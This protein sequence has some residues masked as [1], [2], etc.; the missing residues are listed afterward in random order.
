MKRLLLFVFGLII[1]A[2]PAYAQSTAALIEQALAAA[3]PR[4][5]EGAA[6]IKWNADYTY[7]TLKER[8]ARGPVELEEIDV[9]N[10]KRRASRNT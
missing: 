5:G 2:P 9:I 4:A 1:L 7:E 6:V 3:S 8:I 10:E